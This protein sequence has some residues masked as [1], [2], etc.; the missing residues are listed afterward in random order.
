MAAAILSLLQLVGA[1]VTTTTKASFLL[2]AQALVVLIE[3]FPTIKV[4][5]VHRIFLFLVVLLINFERTLVEIGTLIQDSGI[6]Y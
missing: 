6:V 3:L 5:H 1:T 4:I 2:N